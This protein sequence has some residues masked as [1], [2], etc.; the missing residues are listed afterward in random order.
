MTHDFA[1]RRLWIRVGIATGEIAAGSFGGG[2]RRTCT[3]CSDVVNLAARL[4]ETAKS[5]GVALLADEETA[6][7]SVDEGRRALKLVTPAAE[8][9]GRRQGV[10][11]C[12]LAP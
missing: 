1:G 5:F 7:A 2:G 3:I 6:C 9:R 4:Q 11:V 8:V 10:N 12:S